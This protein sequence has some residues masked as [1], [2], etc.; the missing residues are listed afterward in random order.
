MQLN[1]MGQNIETVARQRNIF[2]LLSVLA[3]ICLFLVSLKL[4]TVSE[5]TILVPGLHQEVWTSDKKVSTS[6]LEEVAVMYLPL[7]LDLDTTSMDWKR[8]RI[9]MHVST[10]DISLLKKLQT[11]FAKAKED[12]KH[13]SLSTHFA[14]ERLET[15]SEMLTVRAHGQLVSRFGNRGFESEP[16]IYELSFEWLAGRLLLKEFEIITKEDLVDA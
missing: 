14:L 4:L 15:D 3:L 8:D 13:F 10:S 12:Y 1:V 7:L 2:L 16:K 9:L 11:Y 5:K 6:Y